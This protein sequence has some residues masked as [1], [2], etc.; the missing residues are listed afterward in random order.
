MK[1]V[2]KQFE[3]TMQRERSDIL[4]PEN[5]F[6][7]KTFPLVLEFNLRMP[8]VSKII[9]R[10]MHLIHSVAGLQEIFPA[11]SIIPAYRRMKNLKDMLAP[12]RFKVSVE[13]YNANLGVVG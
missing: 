1:L 13:N 6:K 5:K 8:N 11:G 12:S 2:D 4:K 10:H 9:K 7:K 3:K